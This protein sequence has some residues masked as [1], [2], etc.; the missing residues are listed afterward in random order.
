[1]AAKSVAP[2]KKSKVKKATNATKAKKVGWRGS[3]SMRLKSDTGKVIKLVANA[4]PGK[5]FHDPVFLCK[6]AQLS[7]SQLKAQAVLV[8]SRRDWQKVSDPKTTHKGAFGMDFDAWSQEKITERWID[9]D[10]DPRATSWVVVWKFPADL[11]QLAGF[12]KIHDTPLPVG[13]YLFKDDGWWTPPGGG[14]HDNKRLPKG[15]TVEKLRY[16]MR[17]GKAV[18]HLE[19]KHGTKVSMISST[20][21]IK[22]F[23]TVADKEKAKVRSL[24]SALY[25]IGIYAFPCYAQHHAIV[26]YI[27]RTTGERITPERLARILEDPA[28]GKKM[29]AILEKYAGCS[30]RDWV[31]NYIKVAS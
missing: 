25:E 6:H 26:F 1:M 21:F 2:S 7:G 22:D 20:V 5:L 23:W 24:L 8:M 13:Y 9:G 16:D 29:T 11:N 19:D 10:Y 31:K 12:K 30:L 18:H 15:T 3:E 28:R 4:T 17:N 27:D 14:R